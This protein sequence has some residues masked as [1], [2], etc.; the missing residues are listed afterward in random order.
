[1]KSIHKET[2]VI[3]LSVIITLLSIFVAGTYMNISKDSK[4]FIRTHDYIS[5]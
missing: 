3:F 4:Y 2:L 5:N 1:M